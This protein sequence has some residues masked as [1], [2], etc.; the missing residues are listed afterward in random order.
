LALLLGHLLNGEA[1]EPRVWFGSALISFG[2]G[3]HQ[4]PTL[5]KLIIARHAAS[6]AT[7]KL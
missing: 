5:R 7:E 3:L 1:I 2:L 4:W 6:V